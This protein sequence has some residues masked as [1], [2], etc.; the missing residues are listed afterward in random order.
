MDICIGLRKQLAIAN[1]DELHI[2]KKLKYRIQDFIPELRKQFDKVHC[3]LD[4]WCYH[5]DLGY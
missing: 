4:V 3:W 5:M 2:L 1:L